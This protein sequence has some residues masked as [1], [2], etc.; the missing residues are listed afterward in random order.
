MLC[1]L[2]DWLAHL[3]RPYTVHADLSFSNYCHLVYVKIKRLSL[4]LCI[5]LVSAYNVT[6]DC[7]FVGVVLWLKLGV[8]SNQI[9]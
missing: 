7:I 1:S 4:I 5:G 9:K 2:F 8:S 6:W 3:Q